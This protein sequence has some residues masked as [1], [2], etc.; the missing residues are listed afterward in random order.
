M[1]LSLLFCII[2]H[3]HVTFDSTLYMGFFCSNSAWGALNCPDRTSIPNLL[4]MCCKH[5]SD[6]ARVTYETKYSGIEQVKFVK[7][8]L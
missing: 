6:E 7:D 4:G 1:A 3:L 2:L 8:S 5:I